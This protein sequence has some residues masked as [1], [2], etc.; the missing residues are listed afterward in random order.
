MW[1]H[2]NRDLNSRTK[3]LLER[4]LRIEYQ[5]KKFDFRT[6]LEN[7]SVTIHVKNLHY[8]KLQNDKNDMF[9]DIMK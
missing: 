7:A 8:P 9:P 2:H 6:S 5:H 3:Q 1:L 4:A